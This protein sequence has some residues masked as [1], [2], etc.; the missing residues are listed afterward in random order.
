MQDYDFEDGFY[1]LGKHTDDFGMICTNYTIGFP[2]K[3]KILVQPPFSNQVLDFS[4]VYGGQ[5]FTDR[6]LTFEFFIEGINDGNR[7][8]L[9]RKWT[10][11]INWL[12][13]ANS[14]QILRTQP[15]SRYYY[16]AELVDPP[17]FDQ[18]VYEGNLQL[19][20]DCYPFRIYDLTE[21]N[22]I[23]DVFDFDLDIAQQTKIDVNGSKEIILFNIGANISTPTLK[24]SSQMIITQSG[25]QFTIPAGETSN[26]RFRLFVGENKFSVSGTGTLEIIWHKELI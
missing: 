7:T 18:M 10:A 1:T 8:S 2:E 14:K 23:W 3:K 17:S 16:L 19:K 4:N 5:T 9:Y 25:T 26:S 12:S 6:S 20:F 22:D 13:Q 21:G 11:I 15:M 24:A